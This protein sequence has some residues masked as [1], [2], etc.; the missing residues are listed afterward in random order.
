VLS[1]KSS[2]QPPHQSPFQSLPPSLQISSSISHPLRRREKAFKV[3]RHPPMLRR[4]IWRKWWRT[5]F[6]RRR[7]SSAGVQRTRSLPNPWHTRGRCILPLL[8]WWFFSSNFEV[9]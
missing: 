3:N 4:R 9:L 8:L 2:A 7:K 6:S 1:Q 5:V